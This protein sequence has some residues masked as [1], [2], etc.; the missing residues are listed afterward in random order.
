[1]PDDPSVAVVIPAFNAAATIRRALASVLGQTQP[2]THIVVV[3][4][5]STDDTFDIVARYGPTVTVIRQENAGVSVA[6]N[7]GVAACDTTWV[8]FLDAD[9]EWLPAKLERQREVLAA[10][11]KLQWCFAQFEEM[12]VR[13][14]APVE[15]QGDRRRRVVDKPIVP[16]LALV[17]RGI[18]TPPSGAMVRRALLQ[19]LGGF[20]Y[21]L[22][23]SQDRDLWLRIAR[24]EPMAGYVGEVVWRYYNDTPRSLTKGGNRRTEALQVVCAHLQQWQDTG[25]TDFATYGRRLAIGYLARHASRA[26]TLDDVVFRDAYRLVRPTRRE[27]LALATLRR[28]PPRA[29]RRALALF[30]LWP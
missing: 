28:L 20:Q 14:W 8:A 27:R 17:E 15:P 22:K 21:D 13:G 23:V 7:V 19:D 5:G 2:P 10:H 3:D 24:L 26:I 16:F 12:T 9:D 6:R 29:A 4:D 30:P 11:P 18:L 1:M 25:Q